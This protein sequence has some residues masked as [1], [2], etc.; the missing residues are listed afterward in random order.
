[1]SVRGTDAGYQPGSAEPFGPNKK[2]VMQPKSL[3][4]V[5]VGKKPVFCFTQTKIGVSGALGRKKQ[6]WESRSGKGRA[7]QTGR[8]SGKQNAI[9][10]KWQRDPKKAILALSRSEKFDV[11]RGTPLVAGARRKK[12]RFFLRRKMRGQEDKGV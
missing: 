3:H 10:G 8:L 6:L 5:G 1:M 9:H 11:S 2:M 4:R 12:D 7:A